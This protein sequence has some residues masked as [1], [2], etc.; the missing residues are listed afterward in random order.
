MI[1]RIFLILILLSPGCSRQKEGEEAIAWVN[2]EPILFTQFWEE[3]K[4]RYDEKPEF[5]SPDEEVLLVL[6][7]NVCSDLIR[8]KLLLQEAAK[9]GITIS[10]AALR[11]EIDEIKKDYTTL[12]FRKSLMTHSKD[13]DQWRESVRNNMILQVLFQVVTQQVSPVT[14]YEI[15][16]Y[17]HSHRDQFLVPETIYL[18]QIVVK[19]RPLAKKIL[20][21]LKRGENFMTLASLY[22]VGPEKSQS[23]RLGAFRKGELPEL[24]EKAAFSTPKGK[25][26]TL[27]ET[28]HG[29][30]IL[31]I[32]DRQPAHVTPFEMASKEIGQKLLQ[33]R[34]K[35]Y[36]NGWLGDLTRNADIRIH[37][38]LK[39]LTKD[40]NNNP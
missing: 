4:S 27:V 8:E 25:I 37:T 6:K 17:Y 15:E 33:E 31:K 22:S 20:R 38:S 29:F 35:V 23:G 21:R 5:S 10:E 39:E 36:Y 12:Q 7:K 18:S 26:T 2:G 28:R 34:Q 13:Y 16:N 11:A 40:T 30:H 3:L 24:L 19:E 1:I 9:R 14:D 32:D